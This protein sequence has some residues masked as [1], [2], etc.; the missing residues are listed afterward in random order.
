[1][2]LNVKGVD[3]SSRFLKALSGI[4]DPEQKRKTIGRVF[5]EVF[6]DE[7]HMIENARW[8]TQALSIQMSLSQYR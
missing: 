8:L 2:G 5:V 4:S 1:M 6:D 3:A 7:A